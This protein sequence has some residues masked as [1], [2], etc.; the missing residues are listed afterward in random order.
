MFGFWKGLLRLKV[1]RKT[2]RLADRGTR[3]PGDQGTTTKK[4]QN[5]TKKKNTKK[6]SAPLL[7]RLRSLKSYSINFWP[8]CVGKGGEGGKGGDRNY[9]YNTKPV[10]NYKYVLI[11]LL[12]DSDSV[13]SDMPRTVGSVWLFKTLDM[14]FIGVQDGQLARN[15]TQQADWVS[16]L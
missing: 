4:T 9:M 7:D 8:F 1:R 6:L 14:L 5:S 16:P 2:F 15:H 12:L 3:R 10:L 13:F 11:F